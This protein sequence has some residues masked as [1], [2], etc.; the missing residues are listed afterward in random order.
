MA[1]CKRWEGLLSGEADGFR[2]GARRRIDGRG[3]NRRVDFALRQTSTVRFVV[4]PAGATEWRRRDDADLIG[5][6]LLENFECGARHTHR[7]E[8]LVEDDDEPVVTTAI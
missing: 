2:P 4:I 8:V 7:H 1:R 6:V 5:V 3:D